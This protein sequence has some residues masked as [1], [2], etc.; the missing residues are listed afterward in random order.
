MVD[1]HHSYSRGAEWRRWDLHIH[2]PDSQ[3]GSSFSGVAW[4]DYVDALEQAATKHQ[5]AVIGVTD[6]MSI[7]GYEKVTQLS[8]KFHKA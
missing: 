4:N 3:L 1:E 8:K 5:I 6:Y 7:D 2:T